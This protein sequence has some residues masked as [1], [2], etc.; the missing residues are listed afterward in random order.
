MKKRTLKSLKEEAKV[1]LDEEDYL[2]AFFIYTEMTKVYPKNKLGYIGVIESKTNYYKKY[3]S[4]DEVRKLK[5]VFDKAYDLSNK[6]E[7]VNLKNNFERYLDDCYE[8]E[9]L[10]KIKKDIVSNELLV[11]VYNNII[12]SINESIASSRKYNLS[13]KRITNIYDL[14]KGIFLLFCLI[15]NLIFKNYLLLITIPFGIYGLIVIYSFISM[16]FLKKEKLLSEKI[17]FKKKIIKAN[18]KIKE[19]KKEIANKKSI[20][21]S[22]KIKKKDNMLKIPNVFND[23]ITDIVGDNEEKIAEEIIDS[24]NVNNLAAFTYLISEKTSLN[25]DEL[26]KMLDKEKENASSLNELINIKRENKKSNQNEILIIKQ[27]KPHDCVLMI[28]LLTISILSLVIIL[29]NFSLINKTSFN[30][31]VITG[32]ISTLIYNTNTGKHSSYTDTLNDSLLLTIFNTT[33]V[34]NLVYSASV[35]TV[36]FTYGIIQM[37]IIFILIFIGFVALISLLKYNNLINKLRK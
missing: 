35:D 12:T 24:L 22:L 15:Y 13:G 17:I 8:V 3:L 36:S 32:I 33:L 14:I 18:V 25:S 5:E 23:Y 29:N 9:N 6:S 26:L 21:E 34:Y 16:N 2:S 31:A 19:L 20:I 27:I 1:K 10:K 11:C 7:K 30:I 4:D 37:P 28:V